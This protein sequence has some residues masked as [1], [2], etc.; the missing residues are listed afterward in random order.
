MQNFFY[1]IRDKQRKTK[2]P[3]KNIFLQGEKMKMVVQ[4]ISAI[5]RID[6]DQHKHFF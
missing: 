4:K 3:F 2:I 5:F 6:F 1:G